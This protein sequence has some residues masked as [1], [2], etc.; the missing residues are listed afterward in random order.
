MRRLEKLEE[1][2]RALHTE[3][4]LKN[5]D[6]Y[7]SLD[8]MYNY[9]DYKNIINTSLEY[10]PSE[11]GNWLDYYKEIQIHAKL[12]AKTNRN[13]HIFGK[14]GHWHTH[15][16]PRCFMCEDNNMISMLVKV[17]GLMANQ[18]PKNIF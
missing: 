13:T 14:S 11:G 6:Q 10:A 9:H 5:Q 18:Y 2:Q 1:E 15:I 3:Q 7:N 4:N 12:Q 16:M 8:P 17:I